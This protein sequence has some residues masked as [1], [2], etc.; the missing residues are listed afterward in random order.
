MNA[1]TNNAEYLHGTGQRSLSVYVIV[2]EC[3]V[4]MTIIRLCGSI[5]EW[6]LVKILHII[7]GVLNL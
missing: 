3:G 6:T 4:T 7:S 2:K 1:T 5:H